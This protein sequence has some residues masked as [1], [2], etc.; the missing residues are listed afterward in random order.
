V[1]VVLVVCAA[2][3]AVSSASAANDA[4]NAFIEFPPPIYPVQWA[5]PA[6]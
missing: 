5:G 1:V 6:A 3:G 2:A 4:I